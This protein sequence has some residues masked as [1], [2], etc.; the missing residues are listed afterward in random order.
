MFEQYDDDE[1]GALDQDDIGGCLTTSSK[2]LTS[3]MDEFEEKT[4]EM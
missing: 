2:V 3:V 4:K 1:I